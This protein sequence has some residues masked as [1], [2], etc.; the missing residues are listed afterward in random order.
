MIIVGD[1]GVEHAATK[2][3]SNRNRKALGQ[4]MIASD[5]IAEA[6]VSEARIHPT[7]TVLEIGTGQGKLTTFISKQARF[8]RTYEIDPVLFN[9]ARSKLSSFQNVELI[10]GDAFVMERLPKFDHCVTSLPYSQSLRFLKWAAV[11]SGT[12]HRFLAIVQTEFAGKLNATPSTESYRAASVIAQIS[13]EI[14]KLRTLPN[15]DFIPQ[16]KVTSKLIR[17]IPKAICDQPFFNKK[18]LAIL[19]SLFSQRK[20]TLGSA[21]KRLMPKIDSYSFEASLLNKR[22]ETLTPVEFMKLIESMEG[23][24]HGE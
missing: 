13:F 9:I 5:A 14:E 11:N 2:G 8:V 20:K 22:V 7:D 24:P 12:I 10:N 19:N 21:L 23:T 17:L 4:H 18:R 15:T 16:P 1:F 6:V 3:R